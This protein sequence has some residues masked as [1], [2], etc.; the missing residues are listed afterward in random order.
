ML[1]GIPMVIINLLSFYLNFAR[2]TYADWMGIILYGRVPLNAFD[3]VLAQIVH[4]GFLGV[5]G[6][7]FAYFIPLVGS[8]HYLFKGWVFSTIVFALLYAITTIYQMPGLAMVEPYT[9]ASNLISS[10][11][12]G[13]VLAEV[14]KRMVSTKSPTLG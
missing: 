13:L 9:V 5:L 12:F 8:S 4:F 6:I 3:N 10:S 14:T 7:A 11:I 2:K 1:A